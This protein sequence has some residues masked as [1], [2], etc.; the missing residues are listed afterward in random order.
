MRK[1]GR[2]REEREVEGKGEKRRGRSPLIILQ[3]SHCQ[4]VMPLNC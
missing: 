4:E 3:F 2:T 1:R